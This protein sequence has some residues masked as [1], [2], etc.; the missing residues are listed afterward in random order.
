MSVADTYVARTGKAGFINRTV[1]A[2]GWMVPEGAAGPFSPPL[3]AT[4]PDIPRCERRT[5]PLHPRNSA[6]A[7]HFQLIGHFLA[8]NSESLYIDWDSI[9]CRGGSIFSLPINASS[10]L[11][12][13]RGAAGDATTSDAT[14][15]TAGRS[16][17][18]ARRC[19]NS[20]AHFPR[21]RGCLA[22]AATVEVVGTH[23]SRS[24]GA[25]ASSW[26]S[27]GRAA[28][29]LSV[30]PFTNGNKRSDTNAFPPR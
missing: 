15:R 9:L 16:Q 2:F 18:C 3:N 12:S 19:C 1:F 26:K 6:Y 30:Q 28:A 17:N 27:C 8:G 25:P 11:T 14:T 23:R 7:M 29:R 5:F 13:P 21:C 4:H 24:S 20:K 22:G 10:Q